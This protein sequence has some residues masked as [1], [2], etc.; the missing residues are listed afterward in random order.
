[1]NYVIVFLLFRLKLNYTF[2]NDKQR[3][4]PVKY[5]YYICTVSIN[6]FSIMAS[7]L[8]HIYHSISWPRKALLCFLVF[9]VYLLMQSSPINAQCYELF[10]SEEFDSTG[11]PD[12]KNWTFETGGGG[13][14][15]NELQYYKANDPDNAWVENGILTITAIKEDFGGRNY[16]SSRIKTQDKFEF[17]YGKIEAFMKLPYGQGIWPAFWLLGENIYDIG[18]PACGEIDIMEMIGGTNRD[19]TSHATLHW[20]NN[21]NHASYGL[22]YTLS[23]GIFADEYHLFAV[24]WTPS[25]IKAYVDGNLFYTKAISEEELS[26][27]HNDFFIILNLAV[28][29]NWPGSPDASTVFP[30]TYEIDY[31]RVYKN[32]ADFEIEGPEVVAEKSTNNAYTITS[33]DFLEYTWIVPADAEITSGQ[34]TAEI[35]VTW[36]CADGE[37]SCSVAGKC[38]TLLYSIPVTIENK[39]TGPMFINEGETGVQ[40]FTAGIATTTYN[41]TVPADATI[42]SG[43]GT[44]SITVD[45]GNEFSEVAVT[46]ENSCGTKKLSYLPIIAGQYPYPDPYT[47]HSI[48]GIINAGD[49]DYGGEGIAYHDITSAN[50]GDGPRQDEGV[51]T[52]YR[53]RGKTNVAYIKSTEWLEYSV[54]VD[55]SRYYSFRMRLATDLSKAGP[56][57]VKFNDVK[58][59]NGYSVS[60]TG[61][62]DNFRSLYIGKAF[63]SESDTIMKLDLVVGGFNV[64]E[65]SITPTSPPV[66]ANPGIAQFQANVYPNP[67]SDMVYAESPENLRSILLIDLSG[68]VLRRKEIGEKEEQSNLTISDIE[69]GA[70]LLVLEL[71]S[72]EH[73][74]HKLI[75]SR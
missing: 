27:F 28:G 10:W 26:E 66:S 52:E 34:G 64:S 70:Y 23:S 42:Q 51:D 17:Q 62:L 74:S 47:P 14:G 45:W 71:E 1:M 21:G 50:Q 68:R 54:K 24:E 9:P 18:W 61:G 36:G 58:V 29:G 15:N 55:S 72:G 3:E 44:E 16:T 2:S 40:I 20:D 39:I 6:I 7:V 49:Y 12:S 33:Y 56:F 32:I 46:I 53:D 65:I 5:K 19:N 63:L 31:V 67:A 57:S 41:W 35:S 43:Q 22:P 60:N 4:L 75:I 13:W 69:E 25:T 48:P 59:L 73:S 30:Q 38:D 37:V 8:K 11:F